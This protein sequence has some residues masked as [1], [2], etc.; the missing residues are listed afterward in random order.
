[1]SVANLRFLPTWLHFKE[2]VKIKESAGIWVYCDI[3]PKCIQGKRLVFK[4]QYLQNSVCSNTW[5]GHMVGTIQTIDQQEVAFQ[6]MC[7]WLLI[8]RYTESGVY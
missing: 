2:F 8:P 3:G 6:N 1:M 5:R 7:T 4:T